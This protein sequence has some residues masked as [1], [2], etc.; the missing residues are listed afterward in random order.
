MSE[1]VIA[2]W[3]ARS[4]GQAITVWPDGCRDLIVRL[5]PGRAPAVFL[6]ALDAAAYEVAAPE[7]SLFWG[8]RLAPGATAFWEDDLRTAC[9]GGTVL[10]Q[11]GARA[12]EFARRVSRRPEGTEGLLAEAAEAWFRPADALASEFV[13]YGHDRDWSRP[14]AGGRTLRRRISLATGA[15][16]RFWLS[17]F[18]VR[19]AAA[20]IVHGLD[21]LAELAVAHG[22]SDQ[23]HMTREVSR[24]LGVTPAVLRRE[25]RRYEGL[26]T[27]P[28]AFDTT[29]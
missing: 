8:L 2:R 14:Y 4:T 9:R 29:T 15:P 25:R 1:T 10:P 24:W 26:V 5:D 6:T 16:P 19:R 3:S 22:F 7:G 17:L 13:A 18:R 12:R 21:S 20:D 28:T 23:A 11:C 27:M